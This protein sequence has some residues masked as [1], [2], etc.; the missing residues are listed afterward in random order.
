MTSIVTYANSTND[1]AQEWGN[2][3]FN[4]D[5]TYLDVQTYTSTSS[6][7][8]RCS[9]LRFQLNVPQGATI[10]SAVPSIHT[11]S[12]ASSYSPD[13]RIYAHD[14]DNAADFSTTPYVISEVQRPRT[15]AY[16]TWNG[17]T[18]LTSNAWNNGPDISTVIQEIVNRPGWSSGNYIVILFI[19]DSDATGKRLVFKGNEGGGNAAYLT[20]DYT[21][22]VVDPG[23]SSNPAAGG[24]VAFGAVTLGTTDTATIV[25]SETG[26]AAL[27]VSNPVLTGVNRYDFSYVESAFPFTIANGGGNVTITLS[28]FPLAAGSRAATL[29]LT[30]NDPANPTV[31]YSLTATASEPASL[32]GTGTLAAELKID[33]DKDE[34]FDHAS[35]NLT[36]R[37]LGASW[38]EGFGM[39]G[40]NAE[41]AEPSTFTCQLENSDG[42]F[43]QENGAATFHGMLVRGIRI[44]YRLT[45]NSITY[46]RWIGA[47]DHI[48][49]TPNPYDGSVPYVT[50]YAQDPT[51]QLL[52]DEFSPPLQLNATTD[53]VIEATLSNGRLVL[54][55]HNKGWVLGYST[56]G[57]NTTLPSM[58]AY[59]DL[60]SGATTLPYAGAFSGS[61]VGS[62][63]Q[64]YLREVV[65]SEL[66]GRFFYNP[67]TGKFTF[68]G[69]RYNT[70]R[71][72]V[73]V[74]LTEDD[75]AS[76]T[77]A[78]RW[79]DNIV[80]SC[81]IG[82]TRLSVGSAGSVLWASTQPIRVQA[83]ETRRITAQY[84][85]PA[86]DNA[87]CA[88]TAFIRPVMG[89]DYIFNSASDGTGTDVTN[90]ASVTV[91]F[92]ANAA[93]IKIVNN[94]GT[95]FHATTLQV[96][97]TPLT[98]YDTQSVT[99]QDAASIAAHGKHKATLDIPMIDD[100]EAVT[101]YANQIVQRGKTA[102][103]Y[104][105][106]I[107]L[108]ADSDPTLLWK[109]LTWGV[110]TRVR[111]NMSG[112]GWSTHDA[113]YIVIGV[114]HQHDPNRIPGYTAIWSLLPAARVE[115]WVL[116]VSKL[117]T[118]TT[119]VL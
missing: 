59:L 61:E 106:A 95:E 66:G 76:D 90:Q 1:D 19:A 115:G 108:L 16:V 71:P 18:T 112:D 84:R 36:S 3:T 8:Y 72:D 114:N 24:T 44:R 68:Q 2:G 55:Y 32:P 23:Y 20:I 99:K 29:T 6:S 26:G 113:E 83:G 13:L 27:T 7:S 30:T 89:T 57:T 103:T 60:D 73:Q 5:Y 35:S 40:V 102:G 52:E 75:I 98:A 15:T 38:T 17:G 110:G 79:G 78:P 105:P 119:L 94:T 74:T 62:T 56:L 92:N 93:D 12:V 39:G 9:G 51:P 67:R 118:N 48:E 97:G 4:V 100:D 47:I 91:T 96:R 104:Y 69:R 37:L 14:T 64:S 31:T 117:G 77:M 46:T 80:N 53:A 45:Y 65:T 42:A 81:T 107:L 116:G 87:R 54:P 82:Y 11:T 111:L 70:L 109:V 43:W 33:W 85:D 86:L 58:A 34:T 63:M 21:E 25:V 22:A 10:N 28:C 88:G 49:L 50:I 101:S 41:F